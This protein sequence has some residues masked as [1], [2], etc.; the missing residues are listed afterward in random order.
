M[1]G[2]IG[3]YFA[4]FPLRTAFNLAIARERK[5]VLNWWKQKQEIKQETG[6]KLEPKHRDLA[7][8]S[9]SWFFLSL[10]GPAWLSTVLGGILP[11]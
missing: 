2:H 8:V 9:P 3:A 4:L 11:G 5:Q 7:L 1:P 6:L 10:L